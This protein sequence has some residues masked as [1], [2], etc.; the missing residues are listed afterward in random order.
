MFYLFIQAFSFCSFPRL[1]V[2]Y[3][4]SDLFCHLWQ[5]QNSKTTEK[6]QGLRDAEA[7]DWLMDTQEVSELGVWAFWAHVKWV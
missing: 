5:K 6:I 7:C 4:H 3:I 2:L 1:G